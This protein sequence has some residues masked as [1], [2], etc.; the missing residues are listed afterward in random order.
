MFQE[1]YEIYVE[2]MNHIHNCYHQYQVHQLD[3]LFHIH[4]IKWVSFQQIDTQIHFT[5]LFSNLDIQMIKYK[6]YKI[7]I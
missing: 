3:K 2:F 1:Y 5:K 6:L 4:C 7:V